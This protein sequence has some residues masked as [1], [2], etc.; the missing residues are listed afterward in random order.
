MLA[1]V[2]QDGNWGG[3]QKRK[4]RRHTGW[5]KAKGKRQEVKARQSVVERWEIQDDELVEIL[6]MNLLRLGLQICVERLGRRGVGN[7]D[8][9]FKKETFR[10][11]FPDKKKIGGPAETFFPFLAGD[12]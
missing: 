7:A 4:E 3:S 1:K 2:G 6:R 8:A 11:S 10:A 12:S 5:A 9:D